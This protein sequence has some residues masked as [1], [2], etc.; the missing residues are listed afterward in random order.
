[1][2][3]INMDEVW[4]KFQKKLGYT[5]QEMKKFRSMPQYEEM[6]KNSMN[7]MQSRIICEVIEARGC[8]GGHKVGQKIVM[9]GNGILLRDEC[10]PKMCILLLGPLMSVIPMVMQTFK[11]NTNP[12]KMIFPRVRCTDV[13]VENGG[14][15]TVLLNLYVE[16]PLAD[17]FKSQK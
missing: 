6:V 13:G 16:G 7:F 17:K 8:M 4:P 12:N 3:S 5:D 2:K 14:W 1:M 9:D 11:D 15:G 10:P